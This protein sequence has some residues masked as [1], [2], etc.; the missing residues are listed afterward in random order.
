[1]SIVPWELCLKMPNSPR[2][3]ALAWRRGNPSYHLKG[4][5]RPFSHAPGQCASTWTYTNS[6]SW[7]SQARLFTYADKTTWMLQ[8]YSLQLKVFATSHTIF[9]LWILVDNDYFRKPRPKTH[10]RFLPL[11]LALFYKKILIKNFSCHSTSEQCR[12]FA[13]LFRQL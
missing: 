10:T 1:M 3:Q 5:Y 4:E 9:E 12:E 6:T 13:Q 2:L 8:K 11:L 7:V